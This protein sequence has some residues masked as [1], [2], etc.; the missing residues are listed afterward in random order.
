MSLVEVKKLCKLYRSGGEEMLALDGVSLE[1]QEGETL[2]L[3]GESGCGK[4]TLGRALLMLDPPS[5]GDVLF[6]GKSLLTASR[7][8]L[9]QFRKEAAA[10]FQDPYSSLSPRRNVLATLEEPLLVHNLLLDQKARRERAYQ[11]LESVGLQRNVGERFPHELSGGQR[12]R[13]GIA[14]ALILS[15]RFLVCDE[16]ISALDVSVQAQVVNL[17][18]SLRDQGGLTLLFIAHDLAMVK[19][20]SNRV[21]VMYLGQI[22]ELAESHQLYETPQHPYT[23]ALLSAIPIPDPVL[24]RKRSKILLSGEVPTRLRKLEGCPFRSRCPFAMARCQQE[25]PLLREAAPGHQVACH[26]VNS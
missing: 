13:V 22:V 3:V 8:E 25:R 20:L 7:R 12:Q 11:L 2:G 5:S 19:Y 1:I 21:A 17:L 18:R 15:P 14:R 23:Q 4:S 9:L 10:V 24:E 16:P 6:A 26:L